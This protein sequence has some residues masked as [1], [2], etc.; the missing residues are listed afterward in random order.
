MLV[1]LLYGI[2]AEST[3]ASDF[4]LGWERRVFTGFRNFYRCTGNS[5]K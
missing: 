3:F 4:L 2:R 5:G 1:M